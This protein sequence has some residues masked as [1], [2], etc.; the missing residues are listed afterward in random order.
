VEAP[1][2]RVFRPQHT[3]GHSQR[4]IA[5]IVHERTD[6]WTLTLCGYLFEDVRAI[7]T[8]HHTRL[9]AN[10]MRSKDRRDCQ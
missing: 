5:H 3:R 8:D 1:R 2:V 9:C 6:G 4:N 10:C 7:R